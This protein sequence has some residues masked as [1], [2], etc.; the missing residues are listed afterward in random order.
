MKFYEKPEIT[1]IIECIGKAIQEDPVLLKRLQLYICHKYS[2]Q[3]LKEIGK[4]FNVGESGVSQSS[5]RVAKEIVKD[6][7]LKKRINK[8]LAELKLS[9][10]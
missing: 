8:I 5:R 2:G 4:H 9:R 3:K 10:V 7:K 1:K 6:N